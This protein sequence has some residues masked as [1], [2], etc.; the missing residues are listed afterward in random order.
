MYS[1]ENWNNVPEGQYGQSGRR[2]YYANVEPEPY[3]NFQPSGPVQDMRPSNKRGA[4]KLVAFALCFSLLGGAVGGGAAWYA[5]SRLHAPVVRETTIQVSESTAA[6]DTSAQTGASGVSALSNAKR[7]LTDEEI[8]SSQ[9]GSVV[10]INVT[11]ESGYNYFGQPVESASSGSG[12]ILTKDGYI[13]TNYHVIESGKTVKVTLYDNTTYDAKIIGG[14]KDYDIAVLKIEATDLQAVTVGD[15]S[16]LKV[17][18][19][20]TTI[21]NPLGELTFSMSEGI[22]SSVNRAINVDGTPFNM[23]QVT[24][25]I[26]PGNSGGPLFNQYGEV[27]GI[28]S[29][30]YSSYSTTTVEGLGFAIPINDVLSMIEDIMTNGYVANKPYLGIFPGTFNSNLAAQYQFDVQAGVII[31]SVEE[32][33]AADKAGLKRDDVITKVDDQDIK[34]VEDLNAAKKKYSAGDKATLTVYRDGQTITVDVIWDAVPEEQQTENT[35]QEQQQ[36]PQQRGQYG[37]G[38]PFND[39]FFNYFFG[40]GFFGR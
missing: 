4:K 20:V 7:V 37:N 6:P 17:G 9:V 15:S 34:T 24:C 14:D 40:N 19:H 35:Q 28:V 33:S 26:N 5:A 8:Y 38:Y 10:S 13:V 39:D 1:N 23:I 32:G 25:A 22:A 11:G 3:R 21:G 12:F 16:Q 36:Q 30:K 29:A 31:Y 27:V 2:Q 18:N